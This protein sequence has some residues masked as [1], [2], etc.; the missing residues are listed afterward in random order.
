MSRINDALRKRELAWELFREMGEVPHLPAS[1]QDAERQKIID[2]A[3][4]STGKVAEM[5]TV[6]ALIDEGLQPLP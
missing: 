6:Q 3:A 5:A 4:K 2:L 1:K